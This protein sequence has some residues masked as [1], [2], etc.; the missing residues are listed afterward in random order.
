L[1]FR[2]AHEKQMTFLKVFDGPSPTE[3]YRRESSVMP[4]Q[5][6]ALA[7]SPLAIAESRR[8][9]GELAKQAAGDAEPQRAF[10]TAAFEQVLTRPPTPDERAACE[11]FLAEQSERLAAASGTASW[12]PSRPA[13]P[14][15]CRRR[16]IRRSAPGKTSSTC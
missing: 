10:V 6:L 14:P 5:A 13:R 3:C 11:Q 16:P 12:P 15:P 7:N 9:A 1:Y 4:Q 8:L 2:H